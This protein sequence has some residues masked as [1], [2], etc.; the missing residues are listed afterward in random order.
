MKVYQCTERF[1]CTPLERY[2]PI[3]AVI[4]VY[5]NTTKVAIKN[6]PDSG[7]NPFNNSISDY[8]YD[9]VDKISM[10]YDGGA[11]LSHFIY[12]KTLPE[13][14]AGSGGGGVTQIIAGNNITVSPISGVG[15]VTIS[16]SGGGTGDGATGATGA[17]GAQGI[18]GIQGF[19][20]ASGIDGVAGAT[21]ATGPTG[22]DG[23][24][25]IQGFT[26]ATGA[27]GSAGING[28]TGASGATGVSIDWRGDLWTPPTIN[29][30]DGV[31]YHNL[32]DRISYIYKNTIWMILCVDGLNGA[33]G[34]TGA[35]GSAG[36][37]GAT[38]ATGAQGIQGFTGANG[39]DGGLGATGAT[40]ATGIGTQGFTGAT[41]AQGIQGIQGIQGFTGAQG[42]QG[43][44]GVQ[45]FTGATGVQGIQ[46]IQG[47]TGAQ[48]IQGLTGETGAT[49]VGT[50]GFTGA[51]GATGAGTAGATGATGAQGVASSWMYPYNA[52]NFDSPNSSDWVTNVLAPCEIYPTNPSL[53]IRAFDSSTQEG[54]GFG[55]IVIP[56]TAVGMKFT[57]KWTAQTNPGSTVGVVWKL[58]S[59]TS[60]SGVAVGAWNTGIVLTTQSTADA[61]F[62]V[63][64]QSIT[65]A[66]LGYTA[67]DYR[68]YELCRAVAETGDTLASDAY[69][70]L[71]MVEF[72]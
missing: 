2:I 26:G 22:S 61:Y 64:T 13:N 52:A 43:D 11:A 30:K 50:Q 60:N 51:T 54:V 44:T 37:N 47:F 4:Y 31:G 42:I 36:I 16:S 20:G 65:L 28:A 46:G 39:A 8:E 9:E 1:F 27:S 5:E 35:S 56:A 62:H 32:S 40:G 23:I 24:Q 70:D 18:Q 19:T 14:E 59:R 33:T 67:G 38:G 48:G 21:G 15:A 69:L 71:F 29:L 53:T 6:A 57:F 58:Y 66:T 17:T 34:A 68:Q 25:G 12:L 3:G 45:G 55:V 7:Q 72:Y 10:F 63:Y 49:G 41:G